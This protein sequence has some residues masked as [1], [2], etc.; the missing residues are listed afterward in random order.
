MENGGS[1][2]SVDFVKKR[3]A[4]KEDRDALIATQK[5]ASRRGGSTD[6]SA[7]KK[8]SPEDDN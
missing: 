4:D 3:A 1:S 6:P 5:A 7:S 2:G 8:R